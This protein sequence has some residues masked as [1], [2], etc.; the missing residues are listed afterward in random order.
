MVEVHSGLIGPHADLYVLNLILLPPNLDGE[1]C[2]SNRS[3][4]FITEKFITSVKILFIAGRRTTT[5]ALLTSPSLRPKSK[6]EIT[7]ERIKLDD[8]DKPRGLTWDSTVPVNFLLE[9]VVFFDNVLFENVGLIH[10]ITLAV[11]LFFFCT[12]LVDG[13]ILSH[14]YSLG[15]ILTD[16]LHA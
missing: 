10:V 13:V 1:S 3:V 7:Q 11:Y 4:C 14:F 6:P 12:E 16:L 9:D 15:F 8:R 5:L 2:H